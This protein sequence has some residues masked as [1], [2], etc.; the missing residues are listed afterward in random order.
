MGFA[1]LEIAKKAFKIYD[2]S[3]IFFASDFPMWDH[4]KELE[5]LQ[6]LGISDDVLENVLGKNFEEFYN[7][8]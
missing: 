8:I 2:N 6:K 5:N 7:R 4:K 1:G 3:H